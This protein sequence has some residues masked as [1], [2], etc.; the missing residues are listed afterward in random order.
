VSMFNIPHAVQTVYQRYDIN[1]GPRCNNTG[2]ALFMRAG[3]DQPQT[4]TDRMRQPYGVSTLL[5][6]M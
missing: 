6:T 4:C 2:A 5:R 1:D 3:R